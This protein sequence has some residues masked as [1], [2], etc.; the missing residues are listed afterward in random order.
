MESKE[1]LRPLASDFHRERIKMKRISAATLFVLIVCLLMPAF[2][3]GQEVASLTGIVTD[4]TGAVLTDAAVTLIDTKTNSSY[5]TKTNSVGSYTFPKVLP[6]PGY[7]LT[8]TK[9]GFESLSV[10][11]I[12][13]A[14]GSTHTQNAQMQVGQISQTVEVN[15]E[16][17]NVSL[18][19]SDTT[20]GN[21]FD[22]Q[23]VHELPVQVRDNPTSLLLF[24][25]G[26]IAAGGGDDPSGN[27]NGA[28]TGARADQGSYTLDGLDVND[29]AIGQ[30]FITV[31]QAPVDSI[32]EFRGET[33]NPLSS[34]GRGSGAQV[35]LVTKSGTNQWHGSAYEYHRNT[36]TEANTWFNDFNGVPRPVLIRNQFGASLGGP[37]VKNKLFF[38]FNYE[39]RRDASQ[40]QVEWTVPLD[41]YRNG[42]VSYINSSSPACTANSRQDTQPTCITQLD[43]AGVE[44]INGATTSGFTLNAPLL[45]FINGR[46]PHANDLTNFGDGINTGGF[47][48]NLPAHDSPNIYVTRID[49]NLNDKM[50]L[51][52]RFTI[53]KELAG[54]NT[55]FPA[56]SE[57]PGDPLTRVQQSGDYS[58][59]VGHTWTINNNMINQFVYGETRQRF[60][61][62][63][64]YNPLGNTTYVNGAGG[65]TFGIIS[66]PYESQSGQ[67]RH[68]P[69]P[70]FRD[71]FTYARGSHTWQAGA[72]FK[73]I[74]V[75]S[76]LGNSY[77]TPAL[78]LGGGLT[79][80]DNTVRPGDILQD[81]ANFAIDNWDAALP[82]ALGRYAG[83][84]TNYNYNAQLSSLPVGTPSLRHYK[85]DETEVYVQDSWKARSDLTVS[86]G[87]RYLFY[88]VPYETNGL[89]ATSNLNFSQY[90]TPRIQ[91]GQQGTGACG[92]PFPACPATGVPPGDPLTSFSLAGKANHAPG[93]YHPDWR[94]FAPRLGFAYNPSFK[95]GLLGRLLGDRKTVIRA[96]AGIV[97]DHPA[98]DSVQFV[99]NQI[100]AV[101]TT[102]ASVP[103]PTST[104][105]V[106]GALAAGP[107][108]GA[109]G[110][111]PPGLP[112]PQTVTLPFSP[113]TSPVGSGITNNTLNYA[114]DSNFK[115]PY[116]ETVS[117]G[118]ERE[119]PGH[120]QLD[121]TFFGRFGRRLTAQADA[122]EL[123]DFRDPTPGQ[124]GQLMGQA[125]ANLSSQLRAA[126]GICQT[127]GTVSTQ[128]FFEDVGF[129]GLTNVIANSFLCPN[130]LRGD[131]GS[132]MYVL[133]LKQLMPY[134][135]GFNPQYVYDIYS[136]NKSASNYDALLTTL[137]KKYSRGLQ[138]DLNYTYAH[139]IDNISAIAN[140]VFGESADFSGGVLCDPINLRVCRG[141]SDFDIKHLISADGLYDLPIGRGKS[142]VGNP[143]G[144]LNQIIG[145]WQV[146]GDMNWHSGFAFTTVANAFPF[147][148]NNNVPAIFDGDTSALKVHVHNDQGKIQLFAN[149]TAAQAAFTYP[150]GF[151]AGSRNNL[152]GPHFSGIDLALNKHFPIREH[153]IL[154]FRAE[155]F[156]ALNH[157][158]FSLPSG[159][160]V[161]ISNTGQFGLISATSSSARVMQ[162]A[163]RLDF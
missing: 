149:P 79:A 34:E 119:L 84:S 129:P 101:F 43:Q 102:N 147:S 18:N 11:D 48:T 77:Y 71:D 153:Y 1:S 159:S 41:S 5:Q 110:E 97:Y 14:V 103:Y 16:G 65:S 36:V 66:Y 163:L 31:G 57:F 89:E 106:A 78:G 4:P 38:F 7:K 117:F 12:Y 46:Y 112:G 131:M 113:F 22:M 128:P 158:S 151:Q 63:S 148:F 91:A 154:E 124:G 24:E 155:A 138:F 105:T 35:S 8:F 94:D 53:H 114:F 44:A 70:V 60:A 139:S 81:P 132:V 51:F 50:K 137:H 33:A 64:L 135:V 32:Q 121:A 54:D 26:V 136:S 55:N 29:Y 161:D 152:R 10:S 130:A 123:V 104:G 75:L 122:G 13:L 42:F 17:A 76:S 85:A 56:P 39:A 52:G 19:T 127:G 69:V 61:T 67:F 59:V 116:S 108:F 146:A 100:A 160:I 98:V 6:G 45:A 134:G 21:N 118:I 99:Q 157:P 37:I 145:G 49:Y 72:S 150:L 141:N 144:W 73:P 115:T 86:Y 15:G 28:V 3:T 25:P 27:R 20:V 120:F 140:N 133:E 96:G 87:L 82:F 143:S 107:F 156:N 40:A 74:S 90:I 88:S 111:V 95:G 109:I 2:L 47:R 83:V 62:P 126:P 23:L 68:I 9:N 58:Y 125:F 92:G 142:F 162:F 30:S 80:L 93:Y